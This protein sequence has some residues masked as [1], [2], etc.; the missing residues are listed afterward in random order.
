MVGRDGFLERAW[1][2][3]T[4]PIFRFRNRAASP[5][6]SF[7]TSTPAMRIVPESGCSSVPIRFSSVVLPLPEAPSRQA[8][9]PRRISQSTPRRTGSFSLPSL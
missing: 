6:P 1:A 5:R 9:S 4:K 7:D 2:W 8:H 3:K